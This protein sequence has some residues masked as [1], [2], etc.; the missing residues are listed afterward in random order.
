MLSEVTFT[1]FPEFLQKKYYKKGKHLYIVI[2]TVT[3]LFISIFFLVQPYCIIHIYLLQFPITLMKM[4]KIPKT[5][6]TL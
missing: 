2:I 3:N 5:V 6:F 1:N 4:Y